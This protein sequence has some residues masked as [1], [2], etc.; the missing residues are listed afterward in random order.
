MTLNEYI[1][2]IE[3]VSGH[4]VGPEGSPHWLRLAERYAE[5]LKAIQERTPD[6]LEQGIQYTDNRVSR[7][8]FTAET[9]ITL[10]KTQRDSL[11][12]LTEY[13]GADKVAAS[14]R[15]KDEAEADA[16]A[17]R[18]QNRIRSI[19]ERFQVGSA[20]TGTELVDVARALG[21]DI[22]PRTVGQLRDKVSGVKRCGTFT[23]RKGTRLNWNTLLPLVRL[24]VAGTDEPQT[25]DVPDDRHADAATQD[26]AESLF[27][28]G[29]TLFA[30]A[31]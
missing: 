29:G 12:V 8:L 6:L 14:D 17:E 26:V 5:T 27:Q 11:R 18:E 7:A 19:I 25:A 22:H 21:A 20:I 16:T 31:I 10:P 3:K 23:C 1:A 2:G 15:A 24:V 28:P 30:P 13:V 9:G 4:P